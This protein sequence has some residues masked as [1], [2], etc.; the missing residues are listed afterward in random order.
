MTKS[1]RVS[2]VVY[3]DGD[4]GNYEEDGNG[5]NGGSAIDEDASW[6]EIYRER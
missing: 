2:Q 1:R 6:E 5:D 4:N 3:D